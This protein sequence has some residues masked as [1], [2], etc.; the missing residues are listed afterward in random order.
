MCQIS[1][2]FT[3]IIVYNCVFEFQTI[4]HIFLPYC[5]YN[6]SKRFAN[7]F[8]QSIYILY[9]YIVYKILK[10]F[11]LFFSVYIQLYCIFSYIVILYAIFFILL[12]IAILF[13]SF[14]LYIVILFIP[15]YYNCTISL[16]FFCLPPKDKKIYSLCYYYSYSI[17]YT[18][19]S[20]LLFTAE[21]I[22]IYSLYML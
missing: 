17:Q 11:I 18:L 5:I 7:I 8:C 15:I 16:F 19:F 13:Y 3:S 10:H 22:V 12:Y 14:P 1:F 20:F 6:L 9:S 21:Q 2:Y 4:C